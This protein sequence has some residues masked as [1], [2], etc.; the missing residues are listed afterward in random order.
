MEGDGLPGNDDN[1]DEGQWL[2]DLEVDSK[3]IYGWICW[4]LDYRAHCVEWRSC[5]QYYPNS[6]INGQN[7]QR[8]C[9]P[10]AEAVNRSSQKRTSLAYK[11][12]RTNKIRTKPE[13]L[14]AQGGALPKIEKKAIPRERTANY[15]IARKK[16]MTMPTASSLI[17]RWGHKMPRG[18]IETKLI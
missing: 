18:R 16:A 4:D 2:T 9:F 15:L 17:V 12:H 10:H 14:A 13:S 3:R 6:L 1:A 7:V 11:N 8:N 5:W